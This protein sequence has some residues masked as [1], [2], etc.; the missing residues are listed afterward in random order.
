MSQFDTKGEKEKSSSSTSVVLKIRHINRDKESSKVEELVCYNALKLCKLS[1]Y[2][3]TYIR[4]VSNHTVK[5]DKIESYLEHLDRKWLSV[6]FGDEVDWNAL[7]WIV[8]WVH[9]T[10]ENCWSQIESLSDDDLFEYLITSNFLQIDSLETKLLR[11]VAKSVNEDNFIVAWYKAQTYNLVPLAKF[12]RKAFIDCGDRKR[13]IRYG[14]YDI[15][16]KVCDFSI[17][18]HTKIY[19]IARNQNILD[20][21]CFKNETQNIIDITSNVAKMYGCA[22]NDTKIENDVKPEVDIKLEFGKIKLCEVQI[23]PDE[24]GYLMEAL[25]HVVNWLYTKELPNEL[26]EE[27]VKAMI[28]TAECLGFG[29]KFYSFIINNPLFQY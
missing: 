29:E 17:Q 3:Q 2:F 9:D 18:C 10:D 5:D 23:R 15:T 16:F 25:Y 27:V 21:D 13:I 19:N 14:P 12:I 6:Q 4:N 28:Q 26:D 1:H 7:R 8:E 24:C 11:R 20:F 22:K